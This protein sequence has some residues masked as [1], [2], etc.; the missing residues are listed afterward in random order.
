VV[1]RA[2]AGSTPHVEHGIT[3]SALA[4]AVIMAR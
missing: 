2:S 4:R 3:I 1:A